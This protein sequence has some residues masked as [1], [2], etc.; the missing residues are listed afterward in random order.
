M[1]LVRRLASTVR[2]QNHNW[3]YSLLRKKEKL[4]EAT[5]GRAGAGSVPSATTHIE[6]ICKECARI[7]GM[8]RKSGR[9]AP[10]VRINQSG[11]QRDSPKRGFRDSERTVE[12]TRT[13]GGP[14]WG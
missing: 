11:F 8:P 12:E 5:V 10:R 7:E 13:V 2:S 1:K 6:Q 14:D 3:G 9:P 4:T